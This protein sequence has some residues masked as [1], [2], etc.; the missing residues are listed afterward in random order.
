[1]RRRALTGWQ[2]K[3]TKGL[4]TY[5]W[6]DLTVTMT[7]AM[8]TRGGPDAGVE[9]ARRDEDSHIQYLHRPSPA[10]RQSLTPDAHAIAKPGKRNICKLIVS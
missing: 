10:E 6:A 1:M 9:E 2:S 4:C 7:A 3:S 5:P 8:A